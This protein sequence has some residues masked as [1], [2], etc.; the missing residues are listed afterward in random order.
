[1][2]FFLG[3]K[4]DAMDAFLSSAIAAGFGSSKTGLERELLALTEMA[5][6]PV[7]QEILLSNQSSTSLIGVVGGTGGLLVHIA[8]LAE[9][10][11]YIADAVASAASAAAFRLQG[12]DHSRNAEDKTQSPRRAEA[13]KRHLSGLWRGQGGTNSEQNIAES[14]AH[15]ADRF[16]AFAGR[17]IRVLRLDMLLLTVHHMELLPRLAPGDRNTADGV[18]AEEHIAAL[19]RVISSLDEALAP[20]LPPERRMYIFGTIPSLT[21]QIAVSML[22]EFKVIDSGCVSRVCRLLSGL[23][24]MLGAVGGVSSEVPAPAGGF[25]PMRQLEK[26]KLYYSLLVHTP[27][28]LLAAVELKPQR[29]SAEEYEALLD[30]NVPGRVITKEHRQRLHA[31]LAGK[32]T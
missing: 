4:V 11:D 31:A 7:R 25:D 22:P 10:A 18:S 14:L 21:M 2:A 1:M 30:V 26:A 24:P 27:D 9:S 3:S 15:A 6:R 5:F 19:G 13:W 23:Q 8:S 32:G 16:R 20:Y 12:P 29:F 17:C 28:S